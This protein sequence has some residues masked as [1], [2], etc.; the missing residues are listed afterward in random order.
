M[1]GPTFDNEKVVHIREKKNIVLNFE[2][3]C[4]GDYYY[5]YI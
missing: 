1:G 5:I 2:Q 3:K 4:D